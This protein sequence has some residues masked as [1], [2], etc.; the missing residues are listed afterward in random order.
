MAQEPEFDSWFDNVGSYPYV[1]G[2]TVDDDFSIE[3][4]ESPLLIGSTSSP[5][6][7]T[8]DIIQVTN[9]AATSDNNFVISAMSNDIESPNPSIQNL[10]P[11]IVTLGN[12]G[13]V[14]RLVDGKARIQVDGKTG[15]RIFE[16]TMTR[17]TSNAV[18][19]SFKGFVEG[20]LGNHIMG[21]INAAVEGKSPGGASQNLFQ[22]G[23]VY[24]TSTPSGELNPNMFLSTYDFGAV[25]FAREGMG[26][27]FPFTL[28]TPRHALCAWHVTGNIDGKNITWR[29]K[30]GEFVTVRILARRK[31]GSD[32]AVVYLSA[33]V[34]NVEIASVLPDTFP[35]RLPSMRLGTAQNRGPEAIVLP[36]IIV[37][38]NS[39]SLS[40]IQSYWGKNAGA[41]DTNY[42]N[43]P[44]KK[45][46]LVDIAHLS[47]IVNFNAAH[48]AAPRTNWASP[49]YGG[50]SSAPVFLPINGKL[51]YT[52]SLYS[53]S[54]YD[55]ASYYIDVINT[56]MN[57]MKAADPADGN[58]Y[59]LQIADLSGFTNFQ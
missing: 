38:H 49:A 57:Q 24:S 35:R 32:G 42:I 6:F 58:T 4:S 50:D 59:A 36:G 55:H 17:S 14:T 56:Y 46:R 33:P 19:T 3:V 27:I 48:T 34:N 53:A 15:S 54:M 21:V 25:S 8:K 18:I 5:P 31:F 45:I 41:T 13:K 28:V 39:G 7:T 47:S 30:T 22:D 16:R 23:A 43:S 52:G 37:S 51:V 10:T 12:D 1:I 29:T 11:E 40:A 20:S 9:S 26:N 2:Q 44:H